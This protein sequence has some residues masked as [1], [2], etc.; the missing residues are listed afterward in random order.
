MSILRLQTVPQTYR[1]AG[2]YTRNPN[3]RPPWKNIEEL[4]HH[5]EGFLI[6]P[7]F[8]HKD[9]KMED[10][11]RMLASD[12]MKVLKVWEELVKED[13]FTMMWASCM[14]HDD[15]RPDIKVVEIAK[16]KIARLDDP[17]V[18][19]DDSIDIH[20]N[21]DKNEETLGPRQRSEDEEED[22]DTDK[23][24]EEDD[25]DKEGED[26]DN[27]DDEEP[28]EEPAPKRRSQPRRKVAQKPAVVED[29]DNSGSSGDEYQQKE[30]DD[31]DDDDEE[32]EE[33]E[34]ED[35]PP[36]PKGKGKRKRGDA[37][38]PQDRPNKKQ[39]ADKGKGKAVPPRTPSP[40]PAEYVLVETYIRSMR[41]CHWQ[42]KSLVKTAFKLHVSASY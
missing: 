36:V 26:D 4:R 2:K 5:P 34:E 20:E 25:E 8:L 30:K 37:S 19:Y 33:D 10:P 9:V 16:N 12:R 15:R 21:L 6:H 7:D 1:F 18:V 28:E 24:K 40:T 23:D 3:A 41:K 38:L 11:S 22:G 42:Y 13:K 29:N 35:E 27:E 14:A 39:K 17:S 32:D 31:D